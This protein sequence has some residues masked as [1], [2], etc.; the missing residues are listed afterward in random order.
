MYNGRVIVTDNILNKLPR[1]RI[2]KIFAR[3]RPW[4]IPCGKIELRRKKNGITWVEYSSTL[5]VC[6]NDSILN[7]RLNS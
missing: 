5:F 7:Q 1:K 6:N 3:K 4:K 2:D